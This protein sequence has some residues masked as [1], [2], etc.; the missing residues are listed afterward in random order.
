MVKIIDAVRDNRVRVCLDTCHLH[1]AGYDLSDSVKFKKFLKE[2]DEMIGLLKLELVHINDSRDRLGDLR[3]RHENIGEGFV[4]KKV[5][6]NFLTNSKTRNL[7]YILE[8]PGFD[9]MGPDKKNVEILKQLRK[10]KP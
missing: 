8:T 4:G 7:P 6:E 3:D 2:F 1:A 9:G 5:F 10:Q